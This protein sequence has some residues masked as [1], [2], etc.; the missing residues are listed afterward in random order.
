MI[1]RPEVLKWLAHR[2]GVEQVEELPL[3]LRYERK[4]LEL[5]ERGRPFVQAFGQEE[6][7]GFVGFVDLVGFSGRVKGWENQKISEYLKPFLA[8][9]VNIA[10]D[11][12]ALV[13][14]TIGDEVMFVL[15]DMDENGG[16]PTVLL[17]GQLL[18]G[19]HDLQKTLGS[20]YPFHIGLAYGGLYV[21]QIQGKGY[22]EWTIVG[23]VVHLAKRLHGLKGVVASRGIAGGFGVLSRDE[24]ACKRFKNILAHIAGF[25]SRLTHE[26]IDQ[27]VSDLKGVSPA[28]CALLLPKSTDEAR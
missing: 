4:A 26:V 19:L 24:E 10:F 2:V 15:P 22:S 20:E 14:K 9:V 13:D 25:A 18:G 5:N 11:R 23:E 6:I 21:D 16:P 28:Y 8:G 12:H 7:R 17:M 3:R 27:P 1:G